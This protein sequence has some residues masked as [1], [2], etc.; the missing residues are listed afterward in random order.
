[1]EIERLADFFDRPEMVEDY[2]REYRKES[3]NLNL[4]N[5]IKPNK[6]V[7]SLG[8]GAGR[9]VRALIKNGHD[10]TALDISREQVESSKK[11][12][13][14]VKH[15]C[16]EAIEYAKQNRGKI[17]FDYIL[18]LYSLLN[19]ISYED[20]DEFIRN[21]MSMLDKDGEAI[22]EVRMAGE[23]WKSFLKILIAPIYASKF[24]AEWKFGEVYSKDPYSLNRMLKSYLFTKR[25]LNK[26]FKD[27]KFNI[28]GTIVRVKNKE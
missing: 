6:I 8:C 10:I 26:L 28:K 1:M 20:I 11:L 9:E 15:L 25:Q 22:F 12:N 2:V 16:I 27:Y 18:G 14:K 19:Y 23:N 4:I 3:V 24:M 5:S 21:L 13:P 17:K 7:L